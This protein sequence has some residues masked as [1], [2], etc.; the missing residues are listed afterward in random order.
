MRGRPMR[1]FSC[2]QRLAQ[3][4]LSF[5]PCSQL[6]WTRM[7]ASCRAYAR[8][9]IPTR[10]AKHD[11][12]WAGASALRLR[13]WRCTHRSGVPF[14]SPVAASTMTGAAPGTYPAHS[15]HCGITRMTCPFSSTTRTGTR[16]M[17]LPRSISYLGGAAGAGPVTGNVPGTRNVSAW[18]I[19]LARRATGPVNAAPK[20]TRCRRARRLGQYSAAK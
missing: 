4:A 1:A 18:L 13:V 7:A 14:Q 9:G 8:T 17:S 10:R 6:E 2:V 5:N 11:R 12:I 20:R 15:P 16:T 3:G 19:F